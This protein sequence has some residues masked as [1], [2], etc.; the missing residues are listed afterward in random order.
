MRRLWFFVS[1]PWAIAGAVAFLP[2]VA[3][4][5]SRPYSFEFVPQWSSGE[6]VCKVDQL[7]Y[8]VRSL[9]I[10]VPLSISCVIALGLWAYYLLSRREIIR[11]QKSNSRADD[12]DIEDRIRHLVELKYPHH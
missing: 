10:A 6:L 3:H 1:A 8:F 7:D 4:E 2:L 9:M 5:I 11:F 12:F